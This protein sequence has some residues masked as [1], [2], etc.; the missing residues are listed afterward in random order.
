VLGILIR[1][2]NSPATHERPAFT[3][4]QPPVRGTTQFR[5]GPGWV[6]NPPVA[7][8]RISADSEEHFRRKVHSGGRGGRGGRRRRLGK[9]QK[10]PWGGV[11][12]A[13][14]ATQKPAKKESST[15]CRYAGSTISGIQNTKTAWARGGSNTPPSRSSPHMC[16]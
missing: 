10:K 13:L 16:F 2:K 9:Q 5:A 12:P 6:A 7:A 4:C 15:P 3:S 1:K 8:V 11:L 14:E